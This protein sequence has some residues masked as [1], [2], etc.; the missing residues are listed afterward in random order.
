MPA[1]MVVMTDGKTTVGRPDVDG[2]EAAAAA[3]VAVSTIAFGTD[4][5]TIVID[6][7]IQPVPVDREPLRLIAEQTGGQFFSAESLGELESVYA[8]I[9]SSIGYDTEEQEVTD[10]FVGYAVVLLLASTAL[11]LLWFQRIP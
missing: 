7:E 5:G 3:D 4:R 9:G 8:D 2:A 10:R 6:G 11:S 1:R